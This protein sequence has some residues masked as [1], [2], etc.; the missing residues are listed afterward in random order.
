MSSERIFQEDNKTRPP[1]DITKS[2]RVNRDQT[3]T[4]RNGKGSPLHRRQMLPDPNLRVHKG[5]TSPGND[6]G[7]TSCAFL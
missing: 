3:C 7:Y 6:R 5:R 1:S 4:I 2:E